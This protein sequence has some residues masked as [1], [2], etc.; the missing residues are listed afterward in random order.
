MRELIKAVLRLMYKSNE[1]L[2]SVTDPKISEVL[3]QNSG[4]EVNLHYRKYLGALPGAECRQYI[5]DSI[6]EIRGWRKSGTFTDD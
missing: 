6:Y 2:F 4:R 1:F 3:Q 5:V